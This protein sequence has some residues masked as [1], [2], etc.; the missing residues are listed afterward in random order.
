MEKNILYYWDF[1]QGPLAHNG[2]KLDEHTDRTAGCQSIIRLHCSCQR[3]VMPKHAPRNMPWQP[4][5]DLRKKTRHLF[6]GVGFTRVL[7]Q[8]ILGMFAICI[9]SLAQPPQSPWTHSKHP[10]PLGSILL[11]HFFEFQLQLLSLIVSSHLRG[12]PKKKGSHSRGSRPA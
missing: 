4:Y 12:R 1:F 5:V 3:I 11:R 6:R 8:C 9:T 10:I 7:F 2:K